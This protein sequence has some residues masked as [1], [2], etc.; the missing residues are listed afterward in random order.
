MNGEVQAMVGQGPPYALA[1][2]MLDCIRARFV[3][4]LPES[5]IPNPESRI[6]NPESRIPN[7]E[8]RIPNPRQNRQRRFNSQA[9]AR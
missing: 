8:S 5:R 1:S 7:P 6:P 2:A 4:A 9:C 3:Q